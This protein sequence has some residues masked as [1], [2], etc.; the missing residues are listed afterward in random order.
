MRNEN[1][2]GLVD[3]RG[4]LK[5]LAFALLAACTKGADSVSTTTPSAT[6]VEHSGHVASTSTTASQLLESS[7]VLRVAD[8]QVLDHSLK[9]PGVLIEPGGVLT[10]APGQDITLESSG[11][12]LVLGT[13]TAHPNPEVTHRVR[14]VDIDESNFVGGG[15]DMLDTD[16]GLWV[17]E[18]GRL[19][20][21]GASKVAW[22]YDPKQSSWADDDEV[23]ITPT[24]VG[25]Y[26]SFSLVPASE[27][28][29]TPLPA[30]VGPGW[31]PEFLNLTRNLHIEGAAEGRA[32]VF[33]RSASPQTIRFAALSH[34]GPN[35]VLGRYPLHFHHSED[36][37]RGSV[38]E[39]VVAIH[40]G[41]H[42][43]VP[44]MSHGITFSS[45]IAFDTTEDPYW[46]D[47]GDET[48]DLV[49]ESCVAALAQIGEKAHR[50]SGFFLGAGL[51]TEVRDCVA[52]GVLGGS[53]TG[54]FAWPSRVRTGEW[55]F[56]G[57]VAHNNKG[58]GLWVWQNGRTGLVENF[59]AYHN[60]DFG[61]SHGAY[62]NEYLYRD[63]HLFGNGSAS[64]KFTALGATFENL[65]LDGAGIT[66]NGV[67]TGRHP[68]PGKDPAVFLN[69]QFSGHTAS[70]VLISEGPANKNA[71]AYDF[72]GCEVSEADVAIEGEPALGI[73][74][75]SQDGES[76]FSIDSRGNVASIAPFADDVVESGYRASG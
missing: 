4:F 28:A 13:L 56:N 48:H 6:T 61:I 67:F 34:L 76:A 38:V 31:T 72:I 27:A 59:V 62:N 15:M 57:N 63:G 55:V 12:I 1:G 23:V 11:N 7:E 35:A 33:I 10:F 58:N 66:P 47:E 20:L 24:G 52:T 17:M 75:R 70:K 40:S 44:H 46:W 71:A 25:D 43:F 26:E 69:C 51:G 5:S 39:G 22:S 30:A 45:C 19:D 8:T 53:E 36:G 42:A 68:A 54:G 2:V 3:R 37:S 16:V 14:F 73:I 60:G 21:V 64:V 41:K 49:W 32:H 18:S 29:T 65:V 74:L 9:V 50:L